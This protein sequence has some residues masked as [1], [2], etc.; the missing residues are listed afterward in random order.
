MIIKLDIQFL[1]RFPQEFVLSFLSFFER[2]RFIL[3]NLTNKLLK[4]IKTKF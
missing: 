3:S 4:Q 1:Q 2:C